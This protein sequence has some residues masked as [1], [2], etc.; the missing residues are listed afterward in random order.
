M[1]AERWIQGAVL[2]VSLV[3]VGYTVGGAASTRRVMEASDRQVMAEY[4]RQEGYGRVRV[5]NGFLM[6]SGGDLVAV[7][8]IRL[9][10]GRSV[11]VTYNLGQVADP[12]G[13]RDE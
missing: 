5:E 6:R 10:D 2:G 11:S 13:W 12:K 9:E 3:V 1:K 7:M 4:L 8:N